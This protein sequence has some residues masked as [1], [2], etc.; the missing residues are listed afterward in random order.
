LRSVHMMTRLATATNS[1][2]DSQCK[3]ID[4]RHRTANH[5]PTVTGRRAD[6]GELAY[7]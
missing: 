7:V 2:A 6:D 4:G 5:Y 1:L 3:I